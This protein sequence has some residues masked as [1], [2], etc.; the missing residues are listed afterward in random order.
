MNTTARSKRTKFRK[1]TTYASLEEAVEAKLVIARK[2][3]EGVDLSF[4]EEKK[5]LQ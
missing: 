5:K 4:F 2:Q 3:L 1:E